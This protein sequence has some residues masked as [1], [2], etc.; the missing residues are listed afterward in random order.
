L[1]PRGGS[2]RDVA[3]DKGLDIGTP[4]LVQAFGLTEHFLL[5]APVSGT[6]L[7]LEYTSDEK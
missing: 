4:L 7:N 6:A 3:L 2:I 5:T 1:Q